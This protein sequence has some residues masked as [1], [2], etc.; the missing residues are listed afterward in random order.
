MFYYL[1]FFKI[2]LTKNKNFLKPT[3]PEAEPSRYCASFILTFRSKKEI[4]YLDPSEDD[5]S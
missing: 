4:Y 1:E 5:G 2:V 3:I